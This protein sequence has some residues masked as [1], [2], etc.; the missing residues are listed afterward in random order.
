MIN[1]EEIAYRFC[2]HTALENGETYYEKERVHKAMREAC[3]QV[4]DEIHNLPI[5]VEPPE[6][7]YD[8]GFDDG[9]EHFKKSI[10][11]IKEEL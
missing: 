11:K 9:I 7:L 8:E 10:L 4:L 5:V 1:I 2:K 6:S 3:K